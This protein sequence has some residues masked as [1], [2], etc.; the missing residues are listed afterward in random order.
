M[1]ELNRVN[2]P[3]PSKPKLLQIVGGTCI[4]EVQLQD[5]Q[6]TLQSQLLRTDQETAELSSPLAAFFIPL[7]NTFMLDATTRSEHI[8]HPFT[9]DI[10]QGKLTGTKE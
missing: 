4:N 2:T 8:L 3:F 9:L 7:V 5:I 1:L 10:Y 6:F